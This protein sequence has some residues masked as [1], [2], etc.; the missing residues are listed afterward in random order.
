MYGELKIFGG[1]AHPALTQELCAYLNVA[2]GKITTY[3]FSDGEIFCQIDENVRGS[4]VFV[5]QPTGPPAN[6]NL[7]ELL[8]MLDAFKRSSAAR[9]TAVLPYFGYGRQDKKDKPR[10]PI[11][12]KLVADLISKAGADRV[13]TMDLHAA[14]IQGF[15]DIPV[16]HLFAAPVILDAIRERNLQDL[17]IVSP[18]AGGVERA[19]AIA[20]RLEAGLAIVDK[21]RTKPN[22]AEVMNVI[23]DVEGQ[24]A[25]IV[26]DIIDT[27][28]TLTKTVDALRAH[29][30]GEVMA[31]GVHGVL[32]GPALERLKKAPIREVLVTNTTP[33]D[34]K[35]RQ[36]DKLRP[37]SVA[38]L[39]GEAVR[40]IHEDS[41]VS[42][43]FV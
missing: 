3:N 35:L 10:V 34:E 32:S 17:T 37:L 15:F 7:V 2:Q 33:M 36:L 18:D 12:A 26:D 19:R 24:T 41:S 30:A 28:G 8:I 27:G 22:E 9:V 23:G 6:D 39:L 40:R 43:L 11:T 31:V 16:D 1:R 38:G 42:S 21:R 20:K 5:V 4:D 13:L 25:L 14:Q 29:G